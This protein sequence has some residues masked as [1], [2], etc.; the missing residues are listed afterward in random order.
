M[1]WRLRRLWLGLLLV[2]AA[3]LAGCVDAVTVHPV[4]TAETKAPDVPDVTGMWMAIG[5]DPD[6]EDYAPLEIGGNPADHRQ[7]RKGHVAVRGKDATDVGDDVC[8]VE[9]GGQLVAELKTPE[10]YT[11]YRQFLVRVEAD[12]IAVCGGVPIWVLLRELQDR[13]ATGYS[14]DTL[15]YTIRESREFDL[16]VFISKPAELREFLELALPELAS[17]CDRGQIEGKSAEMFTWTEF[18]RA[19]PRDAAAQAEDAGQ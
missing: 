2:T 13:T 11:F 16:M 14:L 9:L 6:A 10:P 15:Q 18:E 3:G 4:V 5:D 12:R 8:F 1:E 7:C 17:A 19:P